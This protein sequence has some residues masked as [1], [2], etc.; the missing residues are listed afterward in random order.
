[1]S[2]NQNQNQPNS[3][4]AKT[5]QIP[6]VLVE[7]DANQIIEENRNTDSKHGESCDKP[8]FYKECK[9]K[10]TKQEKI[11]ALAV[12]LNFI[13]IGFTL[14]SVRQSM[15]I[16]K[17]ADKTF[18]INIAK[19]SAAKEQFIR[20]NEPYLQITFDKFKPVLSNQPVYLEY[21]FRNLGP[22]PAKIITAKT[23]MHFADSIPDNPFIPQFM[24]DAFE[25]NINTFVV[26][27]FIEKMNF[28]SNIVL[29]QTHYDYMIAKRMFIYFFG[30][31]YYIDQ[32]TKDPWLYRFNLKFYGPD[33]T[34]FELKYNENIKQ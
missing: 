16:A 33:F 6:V 28:T 30:E 7:K 34:G 13:A 11:A 5:P 24:D 20:L 2:D 8:I 1:M 15:K 31:V 32:L 21:F 19:D 29:P 10:W 4:P 18:K 25:S 12:V 17:I 22:F 23:K 3:E 9:P 26:K 27:D 14:L